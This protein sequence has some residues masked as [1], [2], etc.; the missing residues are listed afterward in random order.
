[1]SAN[2]ETRARRPSPLRV[3]VVRFFIKLV[4]FSAVTSV[5]FSGVFFLPS[6][7][8]PNFGPVSWV[9]L[10]LL[11]PMMVF[12]LMFFCGQV[13][14]LVTLFTAGRHPTWDFWN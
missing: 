4:F 9:D 8:D 12:V 7:A 14:L 6:P 10:L 13:G 1:M 3:A 2:I 5:G 11:G